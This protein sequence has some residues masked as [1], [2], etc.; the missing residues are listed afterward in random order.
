MAHT[1]V[2]LDLG[3]Y[4]AKAV[5]AKM[6]FRG[7]EVVGFD[8]EPVELDE[9]GRSDEQ[10]V[11]EAAGRLLKRLGSSAET[12]HCAISGEHV[13]L[14]SLSLPV[15]ASR[16]LDQVLTFEIDDALPY[17]I[18]D[19][20]FDHV[21]L[22]RAGDEMHLLAAVVPVSRVRELLTGL[23]EQGI[24]PR[25]TGVAPL[26]YRLDTSEEGS[27]GEVVAIVDIGHRRTN[28]AVVGDQVRTT[29][30]ILRGGR[31]FTERLAQTG[32]VTF[33]EA[34]AYK[35]R[36]GLAG[37]VGQVLREGLVPVVRELRQT[38]KGHLAAGGRRVTPV[39]L[40]GGGALIQGIEPY[41][42]DEIGVPV[43]R[44]RADLEGIVK[45]QESGQT[46]EE[47]L[48]AYSL[49]RREE[50]PR[51]KRINLRRGELAFKGDYAF[52]KRR[53]AWAVICLLGILAAWIFSNYSEYSV[54]SDQAEQQRD[55]VEQ[56]T[57]ELFGEA[58]FDLVE[59][60]KRLGGERAKDDPMPAHDAFDIVV[61]LSR[62]IPVSVVHDVEMLEI[63]PKRTTIKGIFDAKIST[64][65]EV[66]PG[67][68]LDLDEVTETEDAGADE[69]GINPADLIKEKLLEFKECFTAIRVGKVQA[70]GER[71]RYQMDIESTCP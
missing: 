52:L 12:I 69:F 59:V 18:D 16:R 58:V 34:E 21:V 46:G 45:T 19:A 71:R 27:P 56:V 7:S 4:S 5:V 65:T 25:E 47:A 30:T 23:G 61:E 3:S 62:R 49:A 57:S 63:K 51:P 9:N 67:T 8:T 39:H 41:L 55:Q 38:L 66:L 35:R 44:L 1:V 54:L 14:T 40:C 68:E 53:V 60:Q 13:Y 31:D 29:R 42:A 50:L 17:D 26:V 64:E 36:D 70:V 11:F 37:K 15:S 32:S 33:T 6:G 10:A 22:E 43:E 24:D 48:L 2:G 28:V 20:V